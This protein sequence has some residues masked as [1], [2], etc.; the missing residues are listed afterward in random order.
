MFWVTFMSDSSR[1]C[2]TYTLTVIHVSLQAV[3]HINHIASI[4]LSGMASRL[5]YSLFTLR[6]GDVAGSSGAAFPVQLFSTTRTTG[7]ATTTGFPEPSRSTT[8]LIFTWIPPG[9]CSAD[10]TVARIR[11]RDPTGTGAGKRTLS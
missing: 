10:T 1:L 5:T 7:S 4:A 2:H 3:N 9:N 8:W 6:E 11:T